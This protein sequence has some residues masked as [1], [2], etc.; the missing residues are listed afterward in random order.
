MSLPLRSVA[1]IEHH[2]LTLGFQ[3]AGVAVPILMILPLLSGAPLPWVATASK[4]SSHGGEIPFRLCLDACVPK[5]KSSAMYERIQYLQRYG[6][7][8]ANS[9]F[10]GPGAESS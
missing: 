10:Y 2:F 4:T 5:Q 1:P 8:K 7:G 9:A 6:H 3:I